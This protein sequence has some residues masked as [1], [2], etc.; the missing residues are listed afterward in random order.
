[1][2]KWTLWK[3]LVGHRIEAILALRD[4]DVWAV[5]SIGYGNKF[6]IGIDAIIE[7]AEC[8]TIVLT[9]TNNILYQHWAEV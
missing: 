1:M 7:V 6:N 3:I 8:P 2:I 4:S 5:L 9:P